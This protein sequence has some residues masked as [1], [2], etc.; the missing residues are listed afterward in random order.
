MKLSYENHNC[1]CPNLFLQWAELPVSAVKQRYQIT[2]ISV[3]V[4]YKQVHGVPSCPEW[5]CRNIFMAGNQKWWLGL[6][7][8]YDGR[9]KIFYNKKTRQSSTS[10]RT[11]D[12]L[13]LH[14]YI[15]RFEVKGNKSTTAVIPLIYTVHLSVTHKLQNRDWMLWCQSK[16]HNYKWCF[17]ISMQC[18]CGDETA[19]SLW[20]R[21][22][23]ASAMHTLRHNWCSTSVLHDEM[24]N[25]LATVKKQKGLWH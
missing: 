14:S 18:C 5:D 16:T 22:A 12:L 15:N 13:C 8:A 10:I 6:N 19:W 4:G 9:E 21:T 1:C 23:S 17:M 2:F 11:Y 25:K 24:Y 20:Q 3:L 7:Y